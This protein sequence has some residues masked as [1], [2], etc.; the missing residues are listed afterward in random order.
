MEFNI[1]DMV[2][3]IS[4]T[5]ISKLLIKK[6]SYYDEKSNERRIEKILK[7]Y[8][9]EKTNLD[10]T[11]R[12]YYPLVKKVIQSGRRKFGATDAQMRSFFSSSIKRKGL[13]NVILSIANYGMTKPQML[14]APF[15]VVWDITRGCNLKCQ[16]CYSSSGV[17]SSDELPK[18][19]VIDIIDE[20]ERAGVVAIA[21]SG[22]EPLMRKDFFEIAK[23]ASKKNIYVA[24]ATNGTLIDRKIASKIKLA[25]IKYVEISIDGA[26]PLTHDT[27]RGVEGAWERAVE[28]IQ[29]CVKEGIM[30][31]MATTITKNN[32]NEIGKIIDFA[33]K[34]GVKRFLEFNFIPTGRGRF[35]CASDLTPEEREYILTYLYKR[36]KDS[37]IEIFSTA[38]QYARIAMQS[39][40]RQGEGDMSFS[41]YGGHVSGE[42]LKLAEFIS[43]CG[44]GRLYCAISA[45]GKVTP[46]VFLPIEAGDLRKERFEDIWKNSKILQ[47]LRTRNN[48]KGN[49]SVCEYKYVCGGCRSRAYGYYGDVNESDPGC[50]RNQ[51]A[52]DKICEK[53]VIKEGKK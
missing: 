13:S 39:I 12:A 51:D 43:G 28:G 40:M 26:T 36:S 20:L 9:G 19:K 29:N 16:H 33:E 35:T 34:L 49:C 7:Y 15:L 5:K 41:F 44:A 21:F 48:L 6:L 31:A 47:M 30:T 52:F 22:G 3:Y 8:V 53:N 11:C 17:R 23:Y 24:M 18:D 50:I 25:G 42:I 38:P 2:S 45:E 27:F 46:C 1:L 32:Y 10:I 37:K 14:S 4:K